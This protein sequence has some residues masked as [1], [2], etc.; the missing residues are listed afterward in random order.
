MAQQSEVA[1]HLGALATLLGHR[2]PLIG[3]R[4]RVD[5]D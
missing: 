1:S 4:L 5:S 3:K 2:K